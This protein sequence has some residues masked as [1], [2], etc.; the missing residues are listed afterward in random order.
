MDSLLK[1]VFKL[2]RRVPFTLVMLLGIGSAGFI[3]GTNKGDLDP[4]IAQRW[5]FALHD[6]WQGTWYSLVTEVWFT[7]QPFMFW[8]I[9]TFVVFSIGVY[10]WRAG[11]QR[12]CSLYWIT[13]IGGTLILTFTFV[14]P[15]YLL[16]T[17]LGQALAFAD[18]VGMSGGGFGCVGGWV[19]RLAVP[20]RRWAFAGVMVYLALHLVLVFDLS[21]DVLHIITFCSGFWLDGCWRDRTQK[22]L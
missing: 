12:A 19:H 17:E 10:E 6:L 21:S 7:H 11:T 3:T 15:L 1:P 18:D 20:V 13:D 4:A 14:L 9:L 16:H 5:G 22:R 8:G 2:I